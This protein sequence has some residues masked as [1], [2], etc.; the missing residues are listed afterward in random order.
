MKNLEENF[1]HVL[2]QRQEKTYQSESLNEKYYEIQII[3]NPGEN[4]VIKY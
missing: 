4:D 2:H 1:T 3:S